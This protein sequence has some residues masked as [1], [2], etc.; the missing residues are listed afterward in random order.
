MNECEEFPIGCPR[1][2][3]GSDQMK[4]KNLKSHAEVCPLE[5]V[6]CPFSEVGCRPVSP[7]VRKDL[8][9]H[10]QSNSNHHMLKLMTAHTQLATEHGKLRNDEK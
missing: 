1:K 5:P 3:K 8:N 10:L 6:Q 2:C 7:L 4:R 9:S